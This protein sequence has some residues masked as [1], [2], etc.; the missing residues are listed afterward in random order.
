MKRRSISR[1]GFATEA[2]GKGIMKTELSLS[3]IKTVAFE[4]LK[5]FSAFCKQNGICFYL[6]NGT[7]LGA[8]KYGGF[9]PWDDDIDVFIPRKD[10]DRFIEIYKNS[11]KY[12][13]FSRECEPA[14][15]FPFAKL[16]DMTTLKTEMNI[17]NGIPLG[18]D[19][20]IFPLD[21]CS[22]HILKPDVQRKIQIYQTG[23]V[24]SK[25]VSSEGK[26]F[27][28]RWVIACCCAMGFDFFYNKLTKAVAKEIQKDGAFMGCLMWPIYGEREV[29]PAEI[30]SATVEIEFEG[31][32]FPAPV[33]Y[34]IYLR[35]LYGD[36][37]K[38]PPADKQRSHH[39]YK[40]YRV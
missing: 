21:S 2:E 6:S 13:L 34:D 23:C 19:I 11:K 29:V 38:D 9:I 17:D 39:K 15:R 37:K 5:H 20:D 27:Y 40:A 10:Y 28:K 12:Q 31:E 14:Y 36:Y 25:F 3:E 30:F 8:V 26:P 22:V 18:V 1:N 24:L 32:K 33:G 16:C 35:S 7:L 4:I